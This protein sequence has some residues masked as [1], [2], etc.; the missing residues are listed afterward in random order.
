MTAYLV[1]GECGSDWGRSGSEWRW[2]RV[3][4]KV[5]GE[6]EML[7]VLMRLL[8]YAMLNGLLG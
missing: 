5:D 1:L 2:K 3:F 4:L 8:A 6:S 7:V